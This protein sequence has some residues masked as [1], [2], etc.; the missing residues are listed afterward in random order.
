MSKG[1]AT[2]M[3]RRDLLA[4]IGT[5]AGGAVMYRAMTSL[6]LAAEST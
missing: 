3:R 4:L 5:A 6:S 1:D 2:R